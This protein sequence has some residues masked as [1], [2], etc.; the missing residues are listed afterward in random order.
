MNGVSWA[1][2]V[3]LFNILTV[4]HVI[5]GSAIIVNIDQNANRGNYIA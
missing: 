2:M 1:T 4:Y 3:Y 5:H